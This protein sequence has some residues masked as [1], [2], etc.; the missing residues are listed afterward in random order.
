MLTEFT[1]CL[2]LCEC[3]QGNSLIS[4]GI[5]NVVALRD[6]L[7]STQAYWQCGSCF[8]T[9]VH[10]LKDHVAFKPGSSGKRKLALGDCMYHQNSFP[11]FYFAVRLFFEVDTNLS[12]LYTSSH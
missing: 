8:L 11:P 12:K 2:V 1:L 10:D 7:L 5:G 3:T 9:Y 6:I 4:T